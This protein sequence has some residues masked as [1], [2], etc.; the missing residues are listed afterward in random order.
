[1]SSRPSLGEVGAAFAEPVRLQ[2]LHELLRGAEL[3]AGVLAVRVG[4]SPSTVSS[5]LNR[6][7]DAGFVHVVARGRTRLFSIASTDVADAVE[8]L[9]RLSGEPAVTSLSGQT[10]RLGMREA[11]S[12][13]DHLA[14]RTGVA[15]RELAVAR[16]WVDYSG[17][18]VSLRNLTQLADE[19]GLTIK[20]S[21]GRRQ[22]V[23]LCMD[24]TEREPHLAGKLGAAVL[25]AMLNANWLQRRRED[26]SLRVTSVG[27]SN[28]VRLGLNRE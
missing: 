17:D 20:L 4:V 11:R 16:G 19:L 18:G 23:R 12:C 14:G 8:S 28:F 27:E 9:L 6:L 3:P 21:E 5:H 10:R 24:W 13:Y 22:D 26:R 2:I 7:L 15:F 1:M 25:A